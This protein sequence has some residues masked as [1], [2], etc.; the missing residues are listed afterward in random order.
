M[1]CLHGSST[2]CTLNVRKLLI[3]FDAN[4]VNDSPQSL[5][6]CLQGNNVFAKRFLLCIMN[7]SRLGGQTEKK[8]TLC[9]TC[10]VRQPSGKAQATC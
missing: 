2:P 9:W 7:F 4:T 10:A 5:F 6:P 1:L 3:G 8:L